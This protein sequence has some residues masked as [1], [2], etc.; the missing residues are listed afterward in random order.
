MSIVIPE[1]KEWP[2]LQAPPSGRPDL[3]QVGYIMVGN[4]PAAITLANSDGYAFM[5]NPGTGWMFAPSGVDKTLVQQAINIAAEAVQRTGASQSLGFDPIGAD[6]HDDSIQRFIPWNWAAVSKG[7]EAGQ[8]WVP[9]SS[10]GTFEAGCADWWSGFFGVS[11]DTPIFRISDGYDVIGASAPH[12]GS[13]VLASRH[14]VT[15]SYRRNGGVPAPQG[16]V[17]SVGDPRQIIPNFAEM[18]AALAQKLGPD[19]FA[20]A[21]AY[22]GPGQQTVTIYGTNTDVVS[23]PLARG[24]MDQVLIGTGAPVGV[25]LSPTSGIIGA[26]AAGGLLPIMTATGGGPLA[27]ITDLLTPSGASG[28]LGGM[29]PLILIGGLAFLIFR[30]K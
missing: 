24:G 16:P 8:A 1:I 19:D 25:N 17:Q 4:K 18:E 30:K 23:H 9:L 15:V 5:G 14:Y 3:G 21:A 27:S 22:R 12:P 13:G 6:F 7:A 10:Q 11:P 26:P 29:M 28:G 2:I 20:A